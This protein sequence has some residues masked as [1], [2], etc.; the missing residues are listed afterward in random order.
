MLITP[1]LS[2][3]EGEGGGWPLDFSWDKTGTEP[4]PDVKPYQLPTLH[5]NSPHYNTPISAL[6][7]AP[8][9]DPDAIYQAVMN[10]Y[11]EKSKFKVDIDLVAGLKSNLD[12][13]N[14]TGWPEISEHYI[15]LVGKMPLYSSTELSRERQWEYQRRTATATAVA[16]FAD[17]L[18][19]RNHAYRMMGLYLS[20]EARAQ[21]RVAEGVAVVD[22]QVG[23]LEKVATA[24][25]DILQ[26][27]AKVTE[28]R[29]SLAAMCDDAKAP[30]INAYLK[31]L[32][33][34][35]PGYKGNAQ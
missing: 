1:H 10:C 4:P 2:A 7:K 14:S 15:G 13:Y 3:T 25:R 5:G 9:P 23:F 17:A 22:E 8:K 32:A 35:P 11:P 28:L 29:L 34:L 31:Q 19:S 18:A 12:Q 6:K 16:Q 26:F 30:N 21:A 33:W 27:E 20:L 24:Q